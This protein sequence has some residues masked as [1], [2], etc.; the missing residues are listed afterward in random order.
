MFLYFILSVLISF[1]ITVILSKKFI[2]VLIS[3]KLNQP[4][5]E[6]GPRWH[7]SK[8]GTPT[9]GG[10]FFIGAIVITIALLDIFVIPHDKRALVFITLGM[11]LLFGVIG[12]IDDRAKL[13][14]KQNEG[15]K[16]YQK[17]LLQIIVASAY[18]A[19]LTACGEIDTTLSIPFLHTEWELG[20]WYYVF[21]LFLIVGVNNSVNLT[22]G[23]DGLCSSVTAVIAAFFAVCAFLM[24]GA[25]GT[26]PHIAYM[27]GALF[28]GCIG[29]LV[30]NW[31]PA[32][33]FMGDT[34]S[35]FLGG[36][37]SGLAF[38]IG[39]P[40]I[41]V[42]VGLWYIMETVSVILQV[43]GYKLT[44]K[45]IFKM[46]PIHHHFEKCGWSEVKI[47]FVAVLVTMM[48]CA[49]TYFFM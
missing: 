5:Y 4:I 7:K 22:D 18:L 42:V 35:L 2:P 21:A 8:A 34:G 45:R 47:V 27:S 30:Y 3:K 48:L 24:P 38:L 1:I 14:K 6:I 19:L 9:M 37:L 10:L 12:F 23:I 39:S 49:L 16:A 29:F 15:L 33:I 28:G 46:A 40:L 13:L 41:I 32:R 26:L 31:N 11:A 17:F 44:K 43:S 36:F 25:E 20:N